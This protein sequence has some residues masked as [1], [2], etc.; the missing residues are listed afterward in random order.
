ML[1]RQTPQ[2]P[3]A[4]SLDD[5]WVRASRIADEPGLGRMIPGTGPSDAPLVIMGERPGDMEDRAGAPFVGPAGQ[6]LDRAAE[7]AGLDRRAA[8]VT[9]AVK[10][11]RYEMRGKRRIHQNPNRAEIDHARW[12]V[13]QELRLV[14][15]RLLLAMGGTAAEMLT[16]SR[17]GLLLPW[18]V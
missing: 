4:E 18:R 5:L 12:W 16:G 3:D 13:A 11:F 14:K 1:A 7:A 17:A 15:P 6:M 9:N 8:Y 2:E 10:R